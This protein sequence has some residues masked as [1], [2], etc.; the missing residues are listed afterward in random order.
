MKVIFQRVQEASVVIDQT[1]VASINTGG[2]LLC[3]FSATDDDQVIKKMAKKIMHCRIFSDHEK[4]MNRSVVDIKGQL[5]VV[6]QFTLYAD[7]KRGNRPSFTKA[8]PPNDAIQLYNMFISELKTYDL[9]IQSGQFG[10]NM[11]VHLVNNGPVTLVLDSD[12][13]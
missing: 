1:I 9:D 7:C 6:S 11:N 5:C 3:G 8:A 2:L 12:E 13:L 10:A 4:N